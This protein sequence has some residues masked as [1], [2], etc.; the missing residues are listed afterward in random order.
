M[1]TKVCRQCPTMLGNILPSHIKQ[2]LLAIIWICTEGEGDGDGI[3]SRLSSKNVFYFKLKK[4]KC[5][6]ANFESKPGSA[7]KTLSKSNS[8]WNYW[9]ENK[10][11]TSGQKV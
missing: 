2:T 8:H 10:R 9:N 5:F 7:M 3:K 6:I 11:T 1:S 4:E